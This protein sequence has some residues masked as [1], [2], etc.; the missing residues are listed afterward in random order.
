[1][2]NNFIR[3]AELTMEFEILIKLWAAAL[4]SSG[5]RFRLNSGERGDSRVGSTSARPARGA[6]ISRQVTIFPCVLTSLI[7]LTFGRAISSSHHF[8]FEC[9]AMVR[10]RRKPLLWCKGIPCDKATSKPNASTIRSLEQSMCA[11]CVHSEGLGWTLKFLFSSAIGKIMSQ[12]GW[13][14]GF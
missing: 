10:V 2:T 14:W 1:M 9:N 6:T 5:G 4:Y 12:G 8:S 7:W 13:V 11:R 3:I